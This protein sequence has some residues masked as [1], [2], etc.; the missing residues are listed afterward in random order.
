[1]FYSGTS[2]NFISQVSVFICFLLQEE[3]EGENWRPP[4]VPKI[5]SLPSTRKKPKKLT[6][7]DR[8]SDDDADSDEDF[9]GSR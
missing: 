7:L 3:E 5:T 1:M 8:A 4:V 6:D 9:K 2:W